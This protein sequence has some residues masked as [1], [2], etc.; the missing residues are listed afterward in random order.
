MARVAPLVAAAVIAACSSGISTPTTDPARCTSKS[1]WTGGTRGSPLMQP[2]NTCIS[3]HSSEGE[4]PIFTIAGTVMQ[5]AAEPI[6][7][8]GTF[9]AQVIITDSNG[10]TFT[11]PTNAAGNFACGG[12]GSFG[13]CAGLTPP[14]HARVVTSAGE[15]AMGSAQTSGD[16]NGCH[17][18]TGAGGA[19]GRIQA[20]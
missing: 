19:P 10:A 2:G 11:L 18:E 6:E 7:C 5:T 9:G 13:A 4:G 3:C 16:C 12:G 8:N 1:T 20:P 15:R 14:Y 17:T